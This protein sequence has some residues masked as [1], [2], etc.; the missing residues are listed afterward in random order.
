M[1]ANEFTEESLK[2]GNAALTFSL[3]FVCALIISYNL[4]FFL[5]DEGT[6]LAWGATA[7]FL[8]GF[9]WAAMGFIIIAL[10]EKKSLKY[11]LINCG[12]LIVAFTLK[13]LIIGAWR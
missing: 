7:G 1:S 6:D 8:A 4:A 2:K 11:V 3:T 13:G 10:F 12:Y 9:G 5:G